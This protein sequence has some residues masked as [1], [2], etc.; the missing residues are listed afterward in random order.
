[1]L[2]KA[3]EVDDDETATVARAVR[4]LVELRLVSGSAERDVKSVAQLEVLLA[5]AC[6]AESRP[7]TARAVACRG[8]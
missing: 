7:C 5:A 3:A 6:C 8:P 1:V 4:C 2:R